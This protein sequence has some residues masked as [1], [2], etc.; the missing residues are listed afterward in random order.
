MA[1][2]RCQNQM[3]VKRRD[4]SQIKKNIIGCAH[5]QRSSRSSLSAMGCTV[6]TKQA[7]K[8]ANV[9]VCRA[10]PASR[11]VLM[12]GSQDGCATLRFARAQPLEGEARDFARILQ[13]KFV[14]DVRPMGFHCLGAEMQ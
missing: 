12:T 5:S 14:F 3:L 4:I 1:R 9:H 8:T 10:S 13:V 2:S 7:V 6:R 11:P